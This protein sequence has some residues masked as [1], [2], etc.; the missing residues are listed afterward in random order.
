VQHRLDST[1]PHRRQLCRNII[2]SRFEMMAVAD[3]IVL[4]PHRAF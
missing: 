3:L 4:Q 2:T 1:K